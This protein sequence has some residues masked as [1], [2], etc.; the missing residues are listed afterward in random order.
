[1]ELKKVLFDTIIHPKK[2]LVAKCSVCKTV[3]KR[4]EWVSVSDHQRKKKH[5]EKCLSKCKHC[6]AIFKE[7]Q[8][9]AD[10]VWERTPSGDYIAKA[11]NGDFLIWKWG[12][13]WKYRYRKYGEQFPDGVFWKRT[14]EDAQRACQK[15]REWKL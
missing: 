15:H 10:I 4:E 13:I 8:P 6:G 2:E 12:K 11:K 9:K 1:M 7:M 3:L 5:I 14:K